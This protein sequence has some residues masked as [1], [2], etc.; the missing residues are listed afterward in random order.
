MFW[1]IVG[2]VA[3]VWIALAVV[4]ALVKGLF[5]VLVVGAVVFGLYLL[6]KA[7]SDSD[8]KDVTRL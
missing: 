8:T 4:G 7:M 2:I 5:W 6:F 3:L 1:K